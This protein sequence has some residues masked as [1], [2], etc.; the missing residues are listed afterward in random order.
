LVRRRELKA[1]GPSTVSV[2]PE[3]MMSCPSNAVFTSEMSALVV[4]VAARRAEGITSKMR[5][6]SKR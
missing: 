3:T 6:K 5:I 4:K 2:A 1:C